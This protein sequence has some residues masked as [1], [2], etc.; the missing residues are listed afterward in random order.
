MKYSFSTR[1]D[2]QKQRMLS[3]KELDGLTKEER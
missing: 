2:D 3:R 1:P